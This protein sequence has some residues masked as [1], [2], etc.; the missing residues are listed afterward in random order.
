LL[1]RAITTVNLWN[2]S[3]LWPNYQVTRRV[4]Y[5]VKQTPE[6]QVLNCIVSLFS[7]Y[8]LLLKTTHP[9]GW[10]REI[11]TPSAYKATWTRYIIFI[12]YFNTIQK[13]IRFEHDSSHVW[14]RFD[15]KLTRLE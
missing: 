9:D 8:L 2:N 13:S 15:S 3:A 12:V 7:D 5:E 6:Y 1:S 10:L 11:S 14:I 4:Y